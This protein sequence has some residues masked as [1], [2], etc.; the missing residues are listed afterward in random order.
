MHD[1]VGGSQT[2]QERRMIS[3]YRGSD[4]T[5]I[6]SHLEQ[7]RVWELVRAMRMKRPF[8]YFLWAITVCLLAF[9]SVG[10]AS[11]QAKDEVTPDVQRLFTEAKAAHHSGDDKTA[12][13]KY[14]EVIKMAPHLAGAYNN[15]GMLYINE[16]DYADAA[17]ALKRCYELDPGMESAAAML[18]MSYYQLRRSA[19]ARPFLV[20]A[21]SKDPADAKAEMNL[22]LVL[23]DLKQPDEAI[24]HLNHLLSR[25]PRN[26]EA[27][28]LLHSVYVQMSD[29]AFTRINE[30]DPESVVAHEITGELYENVHNYFDALVEYK[31]AIDLAPHRPGTHLHMAT[32]YWHIGK[33]RSAEVEFRAELQ[34]DPYNCTARWRL[35]DSILEAQGST[36]DALS[37]LNR[38]IDLCPALLQ[39]HEDRARAFIRLGKKS[40]ALPDLLAA[41]KGAPN[42]PTLHFLLASVYRVQ[43]KTA[44]A[45]EEMRIFEQLQTRAKDFAAEQAK[46]ANAIMKNAN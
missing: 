29:D 10:E 31:K 30:I 27:L 44:E 15:L 22:A 46:S 20:A 28:D 36:E 13:D 8:A 40:E 3:A 35:G 45:K 19:E 25:D 17:E 18:G 42:E 7:R 37:E 6:L 4:Y 23:F 39:A 14:R 34:N 33:W 2:D 5:A 24:T 26:L 9:V 21:V 38:S 11:G 12:I 32:A 41:E 16:E 43:H 1:D